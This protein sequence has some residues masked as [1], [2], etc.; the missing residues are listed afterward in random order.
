MMRILQ[1]WSGKMKKIF[2]LIFVTLLLFP[3]TFSAHAKDIDAIHTYPEEEFVGARKENF[4]K[5]LNLRVSYGSIEDYKDRFIDTFDVSDSGL[6]AL[7]LNEKT[8][9]NEYTILILD[10][11]MEVI[12]VWKFNDDISGSYKIVWDGDNLDVYLKGL[13]YFSIDPDSNIVKVADKENESELYDILEST[14]VTANGSTY[15]IVKT[16]W[17]MK[18]TAGDSHNQL[19]HIDE[20]GNETVLFESSLSMKKQPIIFLCIFLLALISFAILITVSCIVYAKKLKS[21]D[22]SPKNN[23]IIK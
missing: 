15:K 11:N 5:E 17:F 7:G 6:I 3:L 1:L 8:L 16:N 10:S 22:I 4:I 2:T 23:F 18:Y 21:Y 12:R 20:S 19:L 9:L 13:T 14:T